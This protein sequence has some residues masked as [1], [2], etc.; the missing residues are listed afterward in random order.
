MKLWLSSSF[1]SNGLLLR[2][3]ISSISLKLR[4]K[5]ERLGRPSKLVMRLILLL[6][7]FRYTILVRSRCLDRLTILCSE[8]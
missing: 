7:R 8:M 4:I 3:S 5:V 1:F 6:K 2:P